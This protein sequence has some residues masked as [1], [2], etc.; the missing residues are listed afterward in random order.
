MTMNDIEDGWFNHSMSTFLIIAGAFLLVIGCVC[1][2]SH[3]TPEDDNWPVPLKDST[4]TGIIDGSGD[5]LEVRTR[6]S[7]ES[8]TPLG[9]PVIY[10]VDGDGSTNVIFIMDTNI[11]SASGDTGSVIWR[12]QSSEQFQYPVAIAQGIDSTFVASFTRSGDLVILNGIDGSLRMTYPTEIYGY[13]YLNAITAYDQDGDGNEELYCSRANSLFAIDPFNARLVWEIWLPYQPNGALCIGRFDQDSDPYLMIGDPP[14]SELDE[15][16]TFFDNISILS[17]SD[18]SVKKTIPIDEYLSSKIAL[19]DVDAD[20]FNDI[21]FYEKGS[22]FRA[23]S[24]SSFAELWQKPLIHP[25]SS[26]NHEFTLAR[27]SENGLVVF[28][29]NSTSIS[30]YKATSGTKIGSYDQEVSWILASNLDDNNEI[31]LLFTTRTELS[32][33]YDL[34]QPNV[35]FKPPPRPDVDISSLSIANAL[36]AD[37]D[38]DQSLEIVVTYVAKEFWGITTIDSGDKVIISMNVNASIPRDK[39]IYSMVDMVDI[40]VIVE[41]QGE[42]SSLDSVI[43]EFKWP[44]GSIELSYDFYGQTTSVNGLYEHEM[45]VSNVT[46]DTITIGSNLK[47]TIEL[48]ASFGWNLPTSTFCNINVTSIDW[49]G[50]SSSFLIPNAFVVEGRF[51]IVDGQVVL[52]EGCQEPIISSEELIVDNDQEIILKRIQISFIGNEKKA[53]PQPLQVLGM[54]EDHS[55]VLGSRDIETGFSI[56]MT[57]PNISAVTYF[58]II[59]RVDGLT[60]QTLIRIPFIVDNDPPFFIR[61]FPYEEVWIT[62]HEQEIGIGIQD[63]GFGPDM[64]SIFFRIFSEDE[65]PISEWTQPFNHFPVNDTIFASTTINLSE[66]TYKIRWKARDLGDNEENVS[67]FYFLRIDLNSVRF[68]KIEPSGWM[69]DTTFECIISISDSGG[70]GVNA[71]SLEYSNSSDG[72]H[73]LGR[74]TRI[75]DYE[76]DTIIQVI[77][78]LTYKEGITNVLVLQAS[79]IAGNSMMSRVFRFYVDTSPCVFF[80]FKPN[81]TIPSFGGDVTCEITIGDDISGV[82]EASIRYRFRSDDS[83][84]SEPLEPTSVERLTDGY[85]VRVVMKWPESHE[86][87]ILFLASDIA[88]NKPTVHES[89]VIRINVPPTPIISEPSNDSKYYVGSLIWFNA[90]GS[91]DADELDN[92][93]FT[94]ASSRDGVIGYGATLE[95]SNLSVGEHDVVLWI[96]DNAGHNVSTYMQIEILKRPTTGTSYSIFYFLIIIMIAIAIVLVFLKDRWNKGTFNSD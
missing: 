49:G 53:I 61:P 21:L 84:Y 2:S 80:D 55:I 62:H 79:D 92:L 6:W 24:G 65:S 9:I 83:D 44:N 66:G 27:T 70:S 69:I 25:K 40:T 71:S 63:E 82:D 37:I 14:Y 90:S 72:V 88:G 78:E 77:L 33:L 31:D 81:R 64:D 8:R 86:N 41:Y 54:I 46:V 51:V 75:Q 73:G 74:W 89:Y 91:Y 59:A 42:Q 10:D 26:H 85:K 30:W 7:I 1:Q 22:R 94:W 11:A 48:T 50:N 16:V 93:E 23:I 5:L 58:H 4:N 47:S 3:A 43:I 34:Q 13:S 38:D 56:E 36:I 39:T 67:R 96:N 45:L 32:I 95:R 28:L 19:V 60:N 52:K 18:G 35:I 12:S 29:Y 87:Y 68:E 57:S 76:D 20:G 17:T 15:N